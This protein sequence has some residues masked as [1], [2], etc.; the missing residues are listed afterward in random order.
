MREVELVIVVIL[1][2]RKAKLC[3]EGKQPQPPVGR[4]TT[5]VG[6]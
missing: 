4:N 2:N 3:R 5:V 6:N 1:D